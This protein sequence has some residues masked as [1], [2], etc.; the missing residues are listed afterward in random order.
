MARPQFEDAVYGSNY[1]EE[2]E[3]RR[4]CDLQ[5]RRR[6]DLQFRLRVLTIM[7]WRFRTSSGAKTVCRTRRANCWCIGRL[8]G[9][10]PTFAHLPFIV[11]D[12]TA[13]KLSKRNA[14]T[15]SLLDFRGVGHLPRRHVQ[16]AGA[17]G[18]ESG[19]RRDAGIFQ[20]LRINQRLYAR[21]RQQ[22]GRDFRHATNCEWI[23]V[24][25]LKSLPIA[26]FAN[27]AKPYLPQLEERA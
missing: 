26:E 17:V 23:N 20:S 3:H 4:F 16:R 27:I 11:G 13:R 22:S 15:V 19:G 7:G 6:P 12:A 8:A 2:R 25:Y 21:R 24:A 5:K 18:L 9:T 10:P 1:M 14:D